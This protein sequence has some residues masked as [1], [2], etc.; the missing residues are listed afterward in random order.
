MLNKTILVF[1]VNVGNVDNEDVSQYIE[2]FKRIIESK[3]EDKDD[4]IHYIIPVR[5]QETRIECI[6]APMFITSETVSEDIIKKIEAT[7]RNLERITAHINA[8]AETRKVIIEK[9]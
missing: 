7:N 8:V 3:E 9:N 4:V 6:N 2:N 1:Y 5:D